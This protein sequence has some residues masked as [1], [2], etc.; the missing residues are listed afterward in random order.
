[1]ASHPRQALIA[2]A[3][4]LAAAALI[5][6]TTLIAKIVGRGVAG[7]ELHPLQV[8]AGRFGFAL[9]A[10]LPLAA[11]R[12]PGLEGAAWPLHVGRSLCGWAAV[13][14]LFAASALMPLAEA[15][16][17][18]FLSPLVTMLLA[19]AMLSERVGVWR[20]SA[21]ALALAGALVLI[22]PGTAAFQPAATLALAAAALMGLEA[23]FIKRLAVRE[24]ALR[25]LVVNNA[26]GS[27]IAVVAASFVWVPPSPAQWGL[28]ALLGGLMVTA[29]ACFIQALKRADASFAAPF[30]YTTLFFAAVYDLAL[31]GERPGVLATLGALLI[32]AGAVV[33]AWRENRRPAPRP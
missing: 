31:F 23:I 27:A 21:A 15:T 2:V 24:P 20:W 30:F 29:Q 4:M 10:L 11:W 18:S 14:F 26:I 3:A 5:A 9:V 13:S 28:L 19:M 16:A 7:P 32:M 8:S 1:M 12:P 25:I 6:G 22:R 33:L 17:I